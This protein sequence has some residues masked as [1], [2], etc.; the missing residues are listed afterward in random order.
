MQGT[1]PPHVRHSRLSLLLW[2]LKKRPCR[3]LNKVVYVLM[4]CECYLTWPEGL[5]RY[6]WVKDPE[7][8]S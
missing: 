1:G 8:G 4:P 5:G 3:R 7:M 2:G 6:D